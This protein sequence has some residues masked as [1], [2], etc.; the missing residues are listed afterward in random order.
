[1]KTPLL[2]ALAI[3]LGIVVTNVL[4]TKKADLANGTLIEDTIDTSQAAPKQV[5]GDVPL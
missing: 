4:I 1:M 3:I 2:I 5:D